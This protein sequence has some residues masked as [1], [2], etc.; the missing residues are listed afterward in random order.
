[1]STEPPRRRR[2]IR[3]RGYDYREPG[4]YF[5][6]L[7]T[8]DREPVLGEIAGESMSL[9]DVGVVIDER[10]RGLPT[11]F[12]TVALGPY[13]L[14]PNHLHAIIALGMHVG[15]DPCDVV[16]ADPRVRPRPSVGDVKGADTWVRPYRRSGGNERPAL[17]TIIQW[18]KTMTTNEYIRRVRAGEW[19]PFHGR[20]WQRNYWEHIIRGEADLAEIETYIAHNPAEWAW[21]R[22]N[23]EAMQRLVRARRRPMTS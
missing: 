17:G 7:C 9:N 6:T 23:R 19:P 16:G 11:K 15:G 1:M 12:A 8:Q 18:F 4:E 13:V 22:E 21:D 5:V 2:S 14:M 10:W 3:L 20:L